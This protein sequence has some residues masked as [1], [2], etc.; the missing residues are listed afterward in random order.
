MKFLETR[1]KSLNAQM[2]IVQDNKETQSDV[3]E[4]IS[5]LKGYLEDVSYGEVTQLEANRVIS[6][7]IITLEKALI[8]VNGSLG[9]NMDELAGM[10]EELTEDVNEDE[11]EDEP[12][13]EQ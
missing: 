3:L 11:P 13:D 12:E 4:N 7:A 6:N 5:E 1:L 8:Y 10:I 9:E 2:E